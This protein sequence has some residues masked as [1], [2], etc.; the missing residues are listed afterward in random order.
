MCENKQKHCM[1]RNESCVKKHYG[2]INLYYVNIILIRCVKE[3]HENGIN[4]FKQ[5][6]KRNLKESFIGES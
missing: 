2:E 3:S 6:C 4:L 5:S 1:K